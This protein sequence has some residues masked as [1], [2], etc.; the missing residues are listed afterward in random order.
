LE[1]QHPVERKKWSISI[2]ISNISINGSE[3][4]ATRVQQG[5]GEKI[6]GKESRRRQLMIEAVSIEEP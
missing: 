5:K 6:L 1:F 2:S 3:A 4:E